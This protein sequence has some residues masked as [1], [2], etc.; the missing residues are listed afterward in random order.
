MAI[1][2]VGRPSK[3]ASTET[4]TS[5]DEAAPST[6]SIARAGRAAAA[7]QVGRTLRAWRQA[8]ERETD[9]PVE[10]EAGPAEELD[11]EHDDKAQAEEKPVQPV[12]AKLQSLARSQQAGGARIFRTAKGNVKDSGIV[13]EAQALIGQPGI[14]NLEQA[15]NR[16]Y[17]LAKGD[18]PRRKRIISTQKGFGYRH[19]RDS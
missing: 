10:A 16:L 17:D 15:L 14:A 18:G 2:P 9:S 8:A 13:Q 1:T 7:S 19:S 12:A 11:A 4:T 3:G 5:S 6:S